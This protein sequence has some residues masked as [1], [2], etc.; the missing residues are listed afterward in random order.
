MIEP[1][2][3]SALDAFLGTAPRP[4]WR[5]W[6]V[7]LALAVGAVSLVL[8]ALRF[9]NGGQAASYISA[10]A[11]LDDLPVSLDVTGTLAPSAT[12]V[13][14]TA[15]AGVVSE[16]LAA[17]GTEVRAGQVLVRLDPRP[18]RKALGQ[19]RQGLAKKLQALAG[20]QATA[21]EKQARVALFAQVK[22]RSRGLA[23]SDREMTE[24]QAELS[25][26][27]DAVKSAALAVLLARTDI[28][29]RTDALAATEIRSPI[30]GVVAQSNAR[31][32]QQSAPL[33]IIAA[34]YSQLDLDAAADAGAAARLPKGAAARVTVA[35]LP[36][37]VFAGRLLDR[38]T[39]RTGGRRLLLRVTSSGR[40]LR[41]GMTATARL[42]L[43]VH[44]DV[45]VVPNTAL[46]FA[47]ASDA[48]RG[49]AGGSA[50]YVLG[51]DGAPRRE[52]VTVI[53][54]DGTRT[55]IAPGALEAGAR[56]ILGLR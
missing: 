21:A 2:P 20:A 33:F 39:A 24:A 41:P 37:R 9:A 36:G 28:G 23:P 35:D 55:E 48:R 40:L 19:S 16:V 13:A 30:D 46:Q 17:R 3:S 53:A 56:V 44:N 52:R 49:K 47:Q 38:G 5:R 11:V 26:A 27:G 1:D 31:I 4:V 7:W 45:L 22:R 50:V 43:G 54:N 51:S 8:L 6:L 10:R 25:G 14:G 42:P 18:L 15:V 29:E 12:S 34:P 32:G